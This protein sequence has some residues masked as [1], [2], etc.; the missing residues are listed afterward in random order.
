MATWLPANAASDEHAAAA[1]HHARAHRARRT[2]RI[3]SRRSPATRA[4]KAASHLPA[5]ALV[6]AHAAARGPFEASRHMGLRGRE[7]RDTSGWAMY[8]G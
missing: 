2:A 3:S 4:A 7:P 8:S 1:A 5:A 6:T